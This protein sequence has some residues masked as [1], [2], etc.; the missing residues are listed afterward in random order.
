MLLRY[1]PCKGWTANIS[2]NAYSN[3]KE[4]FHNPHFR[5]EE[6]S[7]ERSINLDKI[8]ELV[9][10]RRT[11][12]PTG[13]LLESK[14]FLYI[15]GIHLNTDS[16]STEFFRNILVETQ[17]TETLWPKQLALITH[18]QIMTMPPSLYIA[19]DLGVE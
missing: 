1:S 9:S 7:C 14:D 3:L 12:K 19:R 17:S 4:R 8:I 5:D 2:F 6:S 10:D 18:F 15:K 16:T 13:K 11:P